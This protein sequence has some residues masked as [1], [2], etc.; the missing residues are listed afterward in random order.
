MSD[1][2]KQL[3]KF[4]PIVGVFGHRQVGKTTLLTQHCQT[5]ATLDIRSQR[6]RAEMDPEAFL[7]SA[8]SSPFAIDEAQLCPDLFPALKEHVR[9]RKQPGQ[10]LLSGSVRFTSRKAI[11]ES[12]TGRIVHLELLPFTQAEMDE[13]PACDTVSRAL[14]GD[15]AFLKP[16]LK[17]VSGPIVTRYLETGGLPGA[18][19]IRQAALRAE[20]FE[21]QLETILE[22]DLLLVTAT[23]TRFATLRNILA[24]LA[25]VQGEPLD[26]SNLARRTRVSPPTLRTL[27][28]AFESIFLI[29]VLRTEG[30]EKRPVIFFEDQ[31]EASHLAGA[32]IPPLMNLNRFLFSQIRTPL[33]LF[34]AGAPTEIFQYRTRGGAHVP[35]AIRQK[36]RVLGLITM[37]ESEPNRQALGSALSFLRA[38][39]GSNVLFVHSGNKN[40]AVAKNLATASIGVF[41]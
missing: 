25:I 13:R 29:R 39:P 32:P 20:R 9:T 33:R 15:L 22:R 23:R 3:L 26:V 6:D 38:Y 1:L 11:R 17:V 2:L 28:K 12:L 27:L 5:Y 36:D 24:N 19:F 18:C 37:V 30:T 41:I 34:G 14:R 31:G 8:A 21:S 7:R 40:E 10:F 35:L 16:P 4:S